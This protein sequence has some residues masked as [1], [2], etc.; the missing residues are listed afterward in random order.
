VKI[1]FTL[2]DDNGRSYSG[3]AMLS[4]ESTPIPS[5][6]AR[7]HAKQTSA[8]L[9]DHILGLRDAGFFKEAR[10]G[11][12][13]HAAL[14]EKYPCQTDRVHVALLRLQRRRTLRKTKKST[15]G[16]EQVAYVW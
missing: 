5:K 9:P 12:E 15:D 1:D 7:T 13:V 8:K 14:Q 11:V 16:K 2:T 6:R 10:S 4:D 3:T